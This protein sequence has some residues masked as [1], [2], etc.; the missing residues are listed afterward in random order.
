[1]NVMRRGASSEG[2]FIDMKKAARSSRA[3]LLDPVNL[4]VWL[5]PAQYSRREI[6]ERRRKMRF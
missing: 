1:M 3:R 4:G 6:N 2:T 5:L